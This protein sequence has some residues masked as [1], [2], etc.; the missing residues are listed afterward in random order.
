MII[1]KKVEI[2]RLLDL[3]GALLTDNQREIADMTYN[4]DMSLFEIAGEVGVTRQAVHESLQRAEQALKTYEAKL[5]FMARL[6][7]LGEKV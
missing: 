2:S 4:M 1:E 3:Y 5:G 6:E 7:R